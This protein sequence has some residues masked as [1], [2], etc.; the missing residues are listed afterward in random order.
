MAIAPYPKHLETHERLRDGSTVQVRPVR[1]ED[2]PLVIEL[3]DRMSLEDLR[4][5]FFA[6][7]RRL[8]HTLAARLTQIDYDREIALLA[9]RDGAAL[10]IAHFFADPDRRR[11]EYAIAVRTDQ[12]GRGIGYLLMTRLIDIARQFGIGELVGEVL[13]GNDRMLDMCRVLDF[14]VAPDPNDG[15]VL[16]V[17]KPLSGPLPE[18]RTSG[19]T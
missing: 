15:A 3:F 13:R 19:L 11:A 6:P 17:H 1:P 2:E 8:T 9:L 4:L 18:V 5:R 14:Q 16:R 12:K 7:M 10:G